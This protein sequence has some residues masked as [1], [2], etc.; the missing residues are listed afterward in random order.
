MKIQAPFA[1]H[2]AEE[3]NMPEERSAEDL[4]HAQL[5]ATMAWCLSGALSLWYQGPRPTLTQEQA[6]RSAWLGRRHL[7]CY[8]KLALGALESKRLLYKLRPKH[9][10][11]E[12][13]LDE[14]E[15]L[16][17]NPMA[18]S[19]FIDEDNM[20]ILKLVSLACHPRT[21]KTT[22]ARRY[23]LKKAMCWLRLANN[24]TS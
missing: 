22:W 5:R 19:N 21:V 1:F 8:A 9:H 7:R 3:R 11:M 20:K 18:Q 6:E 23:I 17:R 14:V 24:R 2:L 4:C 13:L 16:H 10:Y 15:R 12:H